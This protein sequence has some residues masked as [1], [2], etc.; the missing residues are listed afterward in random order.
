MPKT[1]QHILTW[2][3]EHAGYELSTQGQL[4]R[5]FLSEET[6]AWQ[7]WLA[8]VTAFT[9]RGAA[10][11][12]NVYKEVRRNASQYWYAS[13][14]AGKRTSKRYLGQPARV[15]F[16]HLETIAS[17]LAPRAASQD[18]TEPA[19]LPDMP[20]LTTSLVHPLL[21]SSLVVRERLLTRLDAARF[22]RLTLLSA[23]AGWGKTTLLSMWAARSGNP[24][25]WLSLSEQENDP[26]RFWVALIAALRYSQ[27]T[28]PLVGER[29]LVLLRSPQPASLET[30]LALLLQDLS[31]QSTPTFLL[32]DDYQ[33]IEEQAIHDSLLFLLEHLP[34][35]LHLIVASRTDP[36]LALARLR[37]R[38]R[39]LELRDADLRF[40][41]EEVGQFLTRT[42]AL[43]L[44]PK[45]IALLAQRT[46]GW[47]AGLH[48]AALALSHAQD[49][50]SFIRGFMGSHRYLMDYVQEDIL[51]HVEQPLQDFLLHCAILP[52]L[53]AAFCQ[54]VTAQADL[55]A[56]QQMLEQLEKANLFLVPLDEER[57]WYRL[58]DLFR[59]ALLARLRATRPELVRPLHLRAASLYE[60]QGE[61]SE[62][63]SQRLAAADYAGAARLIEERAEQFWLHGEVKALFHWIMALPDEMIR[64]H[65]GFV[66]KAAWY[67]LNSYAHT[68]KAQISPIRAQV[69]RLLIRVE[70]AALGTEEEQ[71]EPLF[72]QHRLLSQRIRLLRLMGEMLIAEVS[73]DL[74]QF[75]RLVQQ[76]MQ[77]E[78]DDEIFWQMIPLSCAFVY[79]YTFRGEGV[80][81]LPRLLEMKQRLSMSRDRFALIKVKQWL[82]LASL[83]AGL[84]RQ[85]Q[86]E[87]LE[88][89]ALLEHVK[90][91]AYLAGYFS[92][93]LA[94]VYLEWNHLDEARTLLR[95]AITD[96]LAWQQ[97]DHMVWGYRSLVELEIAAGNLQAANE[98][99]EEEPFRLWE[100]RGTFRFWKTN[101]QVRLWLAEGNMEA[102]NAWARQVVFSPADWDYSQNIGV[103]TLIR[104]QLVR[105]QYGQAL[106]TL[107]AFRKYLD[108]AE[109]VEDT[110]ASLAL[111]ATALHQMG[112]QELAQAAVRRLLHLTRCEGHLRV[113]LDMG[114]PMQKLLQSLLDT[115]G[116]QENEIAPIPGSYIATLLAAFAQEKRQRAM[117]RNA[118]QLAPTPE[119]VAQRPPRARLLDQPLLLEPLTAREQRVLHLLA[120]GRSTQEMAQILVV[121]HNTVK[122]HLRHLYNKLQVSSRTQALARARDLHLL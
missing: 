64:A 88:A 96:A 47:I 48:L 50:A 25:A 1:S 112:K 37:A 77:M 89:L 65:A 87:S 60:Q 104:V 53:S 24:M 17:T 69:E 45:E 32:L 31:V 15:T 43:P 79:H 35:H 18:A 91:R 109:N 80:G 38:G 82:A 57:R 14:T 72:L 66:L 29:A 8:T 22:H 13:R 10:G 26:V 39:L 9:F 107:E 67:L 4:E 121:S 21:A 86:R 3:Q 83:K 111:S 74:E 20:L 81:L 44:D 2:S 49:R 100:E 102:A 33:V 41:E 97:K 73:Y 19:V 84:L 117:L 116:N 114:E 16:A 12:L 46:E 23:S 63:I 42:M 51:A 105:Q 108:R 98:V 59:E 52:R 110:I 113:Y 101:V 103:L 85:T 119:Q 40:Q 75:M 106:A 36:P 62:A 92:I 76:G 5:V 122:T 58:H 94:S 78:L 56:C 115:S 34:A 93:C 27:A 7:T 99:L 54:A 61:W 70:E 68:S 71:Q 11:H 120:A 90:G 28:S 118:S 30:I 95:Q 6:D 55:Q